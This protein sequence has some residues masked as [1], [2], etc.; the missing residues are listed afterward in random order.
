MRVANTKKLLNMPNITTHAA[1]RLQQRGI[2]VHV[3]DCLLDYGR[4]THDHRGAEII[5]FDGHSRIKVR[6]ALG[7][8]A[9]RKLA[10]RLDSYVV[11]STDG[12]VVTVGHRTKRIH[13]H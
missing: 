4:M 11:L 8:D 3:L 9:Y 7:E 12:T 2:P 10:D 5:Y 1:A 13:R 6:S